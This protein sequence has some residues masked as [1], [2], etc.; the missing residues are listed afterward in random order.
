MQQEKHSF[1][2][3]LCLGTRGDVGAILFIVLVLILLII[4]QVFIVLFVQEA[5][6]C[7]ERSGLEAGEV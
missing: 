6:A 5:E 7:V 2:F 1:F 3:F 4:K